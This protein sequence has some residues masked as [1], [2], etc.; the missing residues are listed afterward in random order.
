MRFGPFEIERPLGRGGMAE[1]FVARLRTGQ[2]FERTVCLKRILAEHAASPEFVKAF[3]EEAKLAMRLVHPHIAQLYDFGQSEGAWWMSL[4]LVGGGDLR[5]FLKELG[6]PLPLDLALVLAIDLASA[7]EYAHGLVV[8]G[9]P[10]NLVHR[11]VSPSNVLIDE[12]GNFKLVDFG[13]AKSSLSGS[14]TTTG[15]I[16]GKA[17]YMAPEQGH[18]RKLDQRADLWALGVVLFEALSGERPFEGASDLATILLV[19]QGERKP[20]KELAPHVPDDVCAIV[21][22][23]LAV[24]PD[25]R[26]QHASEVLE[27]LEQR[28]PPPTA[29]RRLAQIVRKIQQGEM[30][31][32]LP[33]PAPSAPPPTGT[34]AIT[35]LALGASTNEPVSAAHDDVTRT[36]TVF[37]HALERAIEQGA[38]DATQRHDSIAPRAMSAASTSPTD[39]A[40]A[41]S[42]VVSPEL[43]PQRL[44]ET[45]TRAAFSLTRRSLPLLALAVGVLGLVVGAIVAAFV[46]GRMGSVA[47]P[48]TAQLTSP[49]ATTDASVVLDAAV[50]DVGLDASVALDAPRSDAGAPDAN[51]RDANDR[52]AND[53]DANDRDANDRDANDRDANDRDAFAAADA[54]ASHD[55]ATHTP[56]APRDGR[57]E[58]VVMPWGRVEI[59]GVDVGRSPY[60]GTVRTGPHR[61]AG[62]AGEERRTRTVRV[63]GNGVT[64]VSIT[65]E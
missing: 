16:K 56:A 41:P 48:V 64:R 55:E 19:T 15:K 11:D 45:E 43:S 29:R 23:L 25:A 35:S 21:E 22:K 6:Q 36:R 28:P 32:D 53:R 31:S 57:I 54:P 58:V 18:G 30:R 61:V 42:V 59:D 10:A 52:D 26:F 47:P 46:V 33:P 8:E 1:T 7:L 40:H 37:D 38:F 13:I 4:E 60:R 62:V 12:Q 2:G 14:D 49:T 24:E 9:R 50:V 5:S 63:T 51:D 39:P 65:I 34:L 27:A 17:C 20:L 44:E 3:Q